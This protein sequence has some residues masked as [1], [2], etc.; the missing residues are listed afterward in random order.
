M[1]A[2]LAYLTLTNSARITASFSGLL[3]KLVSA[4]ICYKNKKQHGYQA[5]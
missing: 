1:N 3:L 5:N 2:I 4:Y